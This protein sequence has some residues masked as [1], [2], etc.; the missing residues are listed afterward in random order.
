[1]NYVNTVPQGIVSVKY[2]SLW[3]VGR[4]DAGGVSAGI[5]ALDH[6]EHIYD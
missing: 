6:G 4:S 2:T 3:R 5:D 1:M